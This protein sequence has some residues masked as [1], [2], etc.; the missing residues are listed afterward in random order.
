MDPNDLLRLAR[1]AIEDSQTLVGSSTYLEMSERRDTREPILAR[2]VIRLA[3]VNA[4]LRAA[5]Q[6]QAPTKKENGA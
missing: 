3:E 5:L 4:K 6:S 1:E 2:A